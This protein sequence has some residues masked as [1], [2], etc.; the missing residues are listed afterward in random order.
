MYIC[1]LIN[2]LQLI[3]NDKTCLRIESIKSWYK[4]RKLLWNVTS[5]VF[6]QSHGSHQSCISYSAPLLIAWELVWSS[7]LSY[8]NK[9]VIY[10]SLQKQTTF[11]AKA[12]RK[13]SKE[14]RNN[15]DAALWMRHCF[16]AY[17]LF[18]R[19]HN[20]TAILLHYCYFCGKRSV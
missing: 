10:I 7:C 14:L 9:A 13:V 15:K 16:P 3:L 4:Q 1:I 2:I 19:S 5:S 17:N 18:S 12:I 20:Q 6:S 11:L 8:A